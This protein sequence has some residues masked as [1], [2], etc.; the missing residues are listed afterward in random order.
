MW[1]TGLLCIAYKSGGHGI[2][3]LSGALLRVK[4][5]SPISHYA[6]ATGL[7]RTVPGKLGP[8]VI[9]H[10]RSFSAFPDP[11]PPRPASERYL[12]FLPFPA[13]HLS[14]VQLLCWTSEC[15][16][17]QT[18]S[19]NSLIPSPRQR[20]GGC[21]ASMPS[22]SFNTAFPGLSAYIYLYLWILPSLDLSSSRSGDWNHPCGYLPCIE[23]GV[24]RVLG[25][26]EMLVD[27]G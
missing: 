19:K 18:S 16:C 8:I 4:G 24:S 15:S 3:H 11:S 17:F 14:P 6:G 7:T 1:P 27:N 10:R 20:W 5:H 2:C 13:A 21:L 25:A 26:Q 23:K 22:W 12:P 9:P